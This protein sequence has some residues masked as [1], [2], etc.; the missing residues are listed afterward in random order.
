MSFNHFVTSLFHHKS[1][2]CLIKYVIIIIQ[3]VNINQEMTAQVQNE[4][5]EVIFPF[6]LHTDLCRQIANVILF[7][8]NHTGNSRQLSLL[9]VD[10]DDI[11]VFIENAEATRKDVMELFG[12]KGIGVEVRGE[13]FIIVHTPDEED[14]NPRKAIGYLG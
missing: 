6:G 13:K 3:I 14:V 4:S 8:S 2:S 7:D 12:S 5:M 9:P 10:L 1:L 11:R